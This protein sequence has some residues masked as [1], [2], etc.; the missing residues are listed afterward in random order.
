MLPTLSLSA[1]SPLDACSSAAL[2]AVAKRA[3]VTAAENKDR[4]CPRWFM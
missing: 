3:A 1:L 4:N 2:H